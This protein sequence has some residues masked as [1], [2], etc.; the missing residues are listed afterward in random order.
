MATEFWGECV[1]E[2]NGAEADVTSVDTTITT[3][4]KR[5]DCMGKS[6][7]TR[8]KKRYDISLKGVKAINGR[9][10]DWEN[11]E[12]DKFTLSPVAEPTRRVSY[13]DCHCESVGESYSV[14]NEM[15]YDV[16]LFAFQKIEE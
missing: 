7:F 2:V 4:K 13:L 3:G 8:G 10:F 9:K 6:G 1:A 16:K 5:V 12:G 14:E 11:L 15:V